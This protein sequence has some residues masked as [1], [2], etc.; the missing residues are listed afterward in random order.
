MFI[1]PLIMNALQY[2]IIDNF[3]KDPEHGDSRY[4]VAAGDDSDEDEDEEW[5]ERQRRRREAGIDEDSDSDI[6]A[7]PK[8]PLKE[9][10]PTPIPD[11]RSPK[12]AEYDPATDGAGSGSSRSAVKARTD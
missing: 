11:R 5:L 12:E 6:E 10:N 8:E 7:V 4:V 2:W 3:I 1:F 9:A